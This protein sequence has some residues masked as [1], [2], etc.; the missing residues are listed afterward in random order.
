MSSIG[1]LRQLSRLHGAGER[2]CQ[3]MVLSHKWAGR[4]RS[5]LLHN[6]CEFR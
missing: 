1:M 3:G 2:D 6:Q 4:H 5:K